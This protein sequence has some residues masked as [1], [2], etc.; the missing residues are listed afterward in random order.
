MSEN[1]WVI[2]LDGPAGSGKSTTALGVANVL[3]TSIMHSQSG[4]LD[5][6]SQLIQHALPPLDCVYFER[7]II[8]GNDRSVTVKLRLS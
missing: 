3:N 1:G 7:I 6:Y 8:D 2:T 5:I 4:S